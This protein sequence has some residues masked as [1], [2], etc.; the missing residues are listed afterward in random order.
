MGAVRR[1]GTVRDCLRSGPSGAWRS[2]ATIRLP[3][4]TA[5]G[6]GP[7]RPRRAV[8]AER[9]FDVTGALLLGVAML[10]V[11]VALSVAVKVESPGPALYPARRVGHR[12]SRL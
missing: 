11:L 7:D 6:G 1:A 9:A 10:P 2:I 8:V 3:E 12:G 5:G 4:R